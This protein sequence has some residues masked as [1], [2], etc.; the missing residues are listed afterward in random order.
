VDPAVGVRLQVRATVNT[1]ST[2]NVLTYISIATTTTAAAQQIEY[3]LPG[4]LLTVNGLVPNSRVKVSRVDTGALLAQNSTTGASLTFDL[5]YT[6]SV[7]IEARN[8]SSTTTYRPWV[9]QATISSSAATTVTALQE[10][11]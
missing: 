5:A 7:R 6:G 1:A 8:A 2:G 10:I 3:P 4:S 11:D 9:T